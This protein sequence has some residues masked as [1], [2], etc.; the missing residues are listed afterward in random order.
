MDKQH[1]DL[2]ISMVRAIL[3]E[4]SFREQVAMGMREN[5]V[6]A[7]ADVGEPPDAFGVLRDA[8][9]ERQVLFEFYSK[10]ASVDELMVAIH[11]L[12]EAVRRWFDARKAERMARVPTLLVLSTGVSEDAL[13]KVGRMEPGPRAH[14]HQHAVAGGA[15][16]WFV[17]TRQISGPGTSFLQLLVHKAVITK[18]NRVEAL[19][20]DKTIA[21][22]ERERIMESIMEHAT[23]AQDDILRNKTSRELVELG[24]EKGIEEGLERGIERGLEQGIERGL[25]QGIERGL[26]QGIE[27]GERQALLKL[28]QHLLGSEVAELER[29]DDLEVLRREVELRLTRL[30]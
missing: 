28:A 15:V 14:V 30:H 8:M 22:T 10:A 24:I 16:L 18:N 12:N 4:E 29:I 17:D 23:Q 19:R 3:G 6:D 27:R 5:L 2:S 1:E 7:V 26:E 11:K 9:R 13:A 20:R 21:H 25:E